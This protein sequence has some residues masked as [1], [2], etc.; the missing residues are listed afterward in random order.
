MSKDGF[1]SRSQAL[2]DTHGNEQK[3]VVDPRRETIIA[4]L[5][6]MMSRYTSSNDPNLAQAI[7]NHLGML[8]SVDHK[9]FELVQSTSVRLQKTWLARV[10]KMSVKVNSDKNNQPSEL[11]VFD[12]T[13]RPKQL[14]LKNE[15]IYSAADES[16]VDLVLEFNTNILH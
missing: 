5:L 7:A 9:N 6:Y 3:K 13:A 16:A 11:K 1:D 12:N 4:S 14:N 2:C 10:E 15:A 8:T